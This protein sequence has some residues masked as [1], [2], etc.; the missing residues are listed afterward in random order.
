[1]SATGRTTPVLAAGMWAALL[2][3]HALAQ[4]VPPAT[5]SAA[6]IAMR[7]IDL[8]DDNAGT[9]P[10]RALWSDRLDRATRRWMAVSSRGKPLP[11]YTLAHVF[12]NADQ[13]VLVSIL[14]TMYDCELPGNGAGA[15]LYARCP[16]RVVSGV[17]GRT[18]AM[19]VAQACHLYVPT[20]T[21][22]SEGPDPQRNMTT[23]SFDRNGIL[24]LRVTQFGRPVPSCDL[25]LKLE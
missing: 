12:V 10:Y 2:L 23:V 5:E 25:D 17:P 4:T 21:N 24:R 13:P 7:W 20:P 8:R 16:M 19:N 6:P 1:M 9:A 3:P 15:D 22:A 18:K 14:F 11:A